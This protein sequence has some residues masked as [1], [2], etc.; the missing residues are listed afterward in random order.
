HGIARMNG[1]QQNSSANG[2]I[3]RSSGRISIPN[4]AQHQEIGIQPEHL[5]DSLPEI[6][7][8]TF[9]QLHLDDA[10]DLILDWILQGDH[11]T[12]PFFN[13]VEQR[14][15]GSCLSAAS[16]TRGQK[17]ASGGFNPALDQLQLISRE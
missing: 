14:V 6:E 1:A 9:V 8:M 7:V 16:G 4:F 5:L 15:D 2:C 12:V 10:V 11:Y 17:H 13:F 3:N